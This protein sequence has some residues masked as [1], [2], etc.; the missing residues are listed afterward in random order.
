MEHPRTRQGRLQ[1]PRCWG[2]L[3]ATLVLTNSNLVLFIFQTW[4]NSA[5]CGDAVRKNNDTQTWA[6]TH[7]TVH[8]FRMKKTPH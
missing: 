6:C 8:D 2:T 1:S 7:T 4:V 3:T 5:H